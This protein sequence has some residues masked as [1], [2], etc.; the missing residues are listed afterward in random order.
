MVKPNKKVVS[1]VMAAVIAASAVGTV[2]AANTS[3]VSSSAAAE[4]VGKY[5]TN[6][7]GGT[8]KRATI[9]ID[10]DCSDWSEDMLIAQGAGWDVANRW[11]GGHENSVLDCYA[12][13]AAWDDQNLYIGWQM[14]NSTDTW[15]NPGDGPLSD[16]G[17]IG[18]VPLILALSTDES[19]TKLSMNTTNGTPIWDFKGGV[20]FDTHVDTALFMSGQVNSGGTPAM[21]KAANASGDIDY[22]DPSSC[23]NFTTAGIEYAM[24]ENF[25]GS[26]L[27]MLDGDVIGPEEEIY[28]GQGTYVD[29]LTM[30][31]NTKYDSFYEIKIPFTALDIDAN[32]VASHGI[33]VMQVATRG[34]SA[35]D[36]IPH[37]PSML[38]NAM[39]SYSADPST[40]A[41]KDDVD[42]ITVPLAQVGGGQPTQPTEAPTQ[43]PTEAPTQAPT[44][45]TDPAKELYLGDV[46]L[47][48]SVNNLDIVIIQQKMV[49]NGSY[50]TDEFKCADAD[51]SGGVNLRDAI[52]IQR[53][54]LG[55][56]DTSKFPIGQLIR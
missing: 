3:G 32:Y 43:A 16:G 44:Q 19:K 8:G 30:G 13:Y 14:V 10:G 20:K 15:A 29:A 49:T 55:L 1:A 46:N 35:L 31:H 38:D 33:G 40:S 45:P 5:A 6:P 24:D 41:E 9:T 11:K 37:D 56:I 42:T 4:T 53:Y 23:V 2:M 12:L 52:I 50:S 28:G 21:F 47:D 27:W 34:E 51:S 36:C 39:D 25:L 48:G 18:N 54:T 7:N 26:E 17:R 22:N